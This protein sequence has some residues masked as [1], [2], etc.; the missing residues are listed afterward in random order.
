[1]GCRAVGFIVTLALSILMAS[2]TAEA[3]RPSHVPR[4]GVLSGVAFTSK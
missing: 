4:I 2:L 1:M 3:Q